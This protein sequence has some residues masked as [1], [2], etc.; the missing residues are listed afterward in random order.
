MKTKKKQVKQF[1]TAYK[2]NLQNETINFVNFKYNI[3][4]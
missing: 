1:I 2:K 4:I 3:K